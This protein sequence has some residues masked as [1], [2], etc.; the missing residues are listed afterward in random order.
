MRRF[1]LSTLSAVLLLAG[2]LLA[3]ESLTIPATAAADHIGETV[4][5]CG[6]V[7]SGRYLSRSRSRLT[8]LNFEKA[9]PHQV[10]TVVIPGTDRHKFDHPEKKYSGQTICVTGRI[11]RY[12]GRPQM[13]V[14]DPRQIKI[15]D[16]TDTN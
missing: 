8:F 2:L 12:Q 15:A 7:V 3:G 4:T 11:Q 16:K 13:V 14:T 10:F 6:K 9:Y 5:V 1:T